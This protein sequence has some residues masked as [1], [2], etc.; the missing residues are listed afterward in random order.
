[1][2][3]RPDPRDDEDVHAGAGCGR[4]SRPTVQNAASTTAPTSTPPAAP[5]APYAAPSTST[6]GTSVAT[7]ST[8]PAVRRPT[9]PIET[10]KVRVQPKTRWIAATSSITRNALAAGSYLVP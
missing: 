8:C 1:D 9:R 4:R 2:V 6:A 7:S 3:R 5:V 10:G